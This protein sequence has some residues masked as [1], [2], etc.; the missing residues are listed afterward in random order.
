MGYDKAHLIEKTTEIAIHTPK[1]LSQL[2]V[3]FLFD[4]RIFPDNI[5]TFLAQWTVEKRTMQPGDTIVQQVYIPPVKIVSQKIVFGVRIKEIINEENR[6]GF[7]YETLEGHVEKGISTFI[8]EQQNTEVLFKIHTYS[9]PGNSLAK[10]LGPVFSVPYQ[11]FCTNAAM[12][13]VKR[14]LEA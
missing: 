6:K 12:K 9:A 8:V 1:K 13:N 11:T 7:S 10:L 4:Y 2:N 14:Q 3:D 5:L